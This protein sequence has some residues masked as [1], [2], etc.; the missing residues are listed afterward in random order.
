PENILLE[1]LDGTLVPK[2][3][4]FGLAIVDR[5]DDRDN[6][7]G[8][9]VVAGTWQ[10]MAP[11]QLQGRMVSGAC[12]VYAIGQIGCEMLAARPAFPGRT[13]DVVLEKTTRDGLAFGP[14]LGVSDELKELLF[15]C[16]R[17]DPER[18]PS[19]ESA[20][21]AIRGLLP[22]LDAQTRLVPVNLMLI[23]P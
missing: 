12:D 16:T 4:D 8:I 1:H 19:A 22:V 17:I 20:A 11:E 6:M 3:L 18:R 9:G 23:G 13:H 10:Y 7:T 5:L 21:A 14:W 2:I 15:A